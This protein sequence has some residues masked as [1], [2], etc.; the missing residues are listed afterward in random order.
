MPP[1]ILGI[2][3]TEHSA[4]GAAA[5]AVTSAIGMNVAVGDHVIVAGTSQ[6][7][8]GVTDSKGNN[9][10]V[11]V[12][13]PSMWL[14]DARIT[15]P[16]V[17]GDTITVTR[18]AGGS[19][20]MQA[21]AVSGLASTNW[22]DAAAGGTFTGT[23][24][25]GPAIT[26]TVP[27]DL[28][29]GFFKGTWNSGG[30]QPAITTPG[31]GYTDQTGFGMAGA[32]GEFAG[33]GFDWESKIA[34]AA[35]SEQATATWNLS[36]QS[37]LGI[38]AAYS[39]T[40]VPIK[41]V[42]D[43]GNFSWSD[44]SGS[45]NPFTITVP[46]GGVAVGNFVVMFGWMNGNLI[47][48]VADTR[49]NA[50]NVRSTGVADMAL[51]DAKITTSL[52]AGDTITV[53]RAGGPGNS[54]I[55]LVA[56]EFSGLADTD[57]FDSLASATFSSTTAA[58]AGARTHDSPEGLALGMFKLAVS[59]LNIA[60]PGAG[61]TNLTGQLRVVGE[62]GTASVDWEYKAGGIAS[63]ITPTATLSGACSG[64]GLTVVYRAPAAP[65][66]NPFMGVV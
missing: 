57:W 52:Q 45:L 17:I 32:A 63:P 9:Y 16:L 47:T 44:A 5:A 62:G 21:I 49:G 15:T 43:I 58:T 13:G 54:A 6:A 7:L 66:A 50:Y 2:I 55:T 33:H 42:K 8:V 51:V 24:A 25:A 34:G 18:N 64:T 14:A 4:G 23:A 29:L 39:A 26:T 31:S 3:E 53:T 65:A 19:Y 11:R 30:A 27:G 12:A 40:P 46:T 1:S 28:V 41:F 37:Q 60:T 48:G 38:T 10:V 22:F 61:F 36:G 56:A 35:G 20:Y 59:S